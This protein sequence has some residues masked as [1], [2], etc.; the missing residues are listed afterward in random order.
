[1]DPATVVASLSLE[2]LSEELEFLRLLVFDVLKM[3]CS[4]CNKRLEVERQSA[5]T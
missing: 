4:A 5:Q 3:N 2:G 1:M